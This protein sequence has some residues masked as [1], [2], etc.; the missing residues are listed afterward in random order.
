M[1]KSKLRPEDHAAYDAVNKLLP[2]A[3]GYAPDSAPW[4][5]EWALHQSFLAG[6]QWERDRQAQKPK[7]PQ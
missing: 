4:W 6:V 2:R 1:A 3:D 7:T 5:H